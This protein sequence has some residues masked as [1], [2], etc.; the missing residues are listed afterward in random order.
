MTFEPIEGTYEDFYVPRFEIATSGT[1]Y[2]D[3][4]GEI[5]QLSVKT[6]VE[7]ANRFSFTLTHPFDLERR[8][9]EEIDWASL[10]RDRPVEISMGYADTLKPVFLGSVQSAEPSFPTSGVPTIEV[11][12]YG[13]LHE[14][15]VGNRTKTW[16]R[17]TVEDRVTDAAVVQKVLDRGSY[18]FGGTTID[19]TELEFTRIIQDNK[20]DYQFLTERA[21]RYNYEV[22]THRDEFYFRAP[23]DDDPPTLTLAYGESLLSF[24]P[25]RNQA[26]DVSEVVVR[27]SDRNGREEIV[28]RA[29][30]EEP[31]GDPRV[32]RMPVESKREA[33]RVAEA[34]AVRIRQDRLRGS[35]E[36]I[37][38]PELVAGITVQLEGLTG[39][40]NGLYYVESAEHR[41]STDGYVTS[42]QVRGAS[43]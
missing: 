15:M 13:R 9:F 30:G 23:H 17:D 34:E 36:T 29:S 2:T 14:L 8:E 6:S 12:G 22:F 42:F 7:G 35:G 11:S 28:G 43:A 18:G 26:N 39:E 31:S 16:D 19:D 20:S 24:S 27:W 38:I 10:E 21:R 5:A 37:G 1:T 40:F 32:V 25:Q 41:L 4:T 33:D 3:A